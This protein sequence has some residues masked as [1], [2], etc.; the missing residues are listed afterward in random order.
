ME[1]SVHVATGEAAATSLDATAAGQEQERVYDTVLLSEMEYV[2][3]DATYYYQCPCG[4]MFEI[5]EEDLAN[6]VTIARCPS[7][8]LKVRVDMPLPSSSEVKGAG[9]PENGSTT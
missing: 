5:T 7:C 1:A 4:D 3:E 8:S 6:G 9:Y 2:E